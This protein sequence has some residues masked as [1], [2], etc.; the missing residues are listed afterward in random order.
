MD[1]GDL[2]ERVS[3]VGCWPSRSGASSTA[4]SPHRTAPSAA[5]RPLRGRHRASTPAK[6]HLD[7]LVEEGLLDTEFKRLTGKQGPGAG[8]PTKLYRRSARE[9]S[10]TV[11]ERHYDVVGHLRPQPSRSPRTTAPPSSTRCTTS[12]LRWA[13]RAITLANCPFHYLAREH[14]QLVCGITF[15]LISE[16]VQHAADE[17]S[18]AQARS[19]R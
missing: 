4:T 6:F 12:R 15:A 14:T 1:V 3:G 18:D 8:R 9:L 2:A 13:A 17:K 7:E 11:P 10:V 16:M 5:I 19:G